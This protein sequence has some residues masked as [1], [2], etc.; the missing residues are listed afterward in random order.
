[1]PTRFYPVLIIALST[2]WLG[3]CAS[4]APSG[5]VADNA[6]H[7]A[8]AAPSPEA[9]M[10]FPKLTKGISAAEVRQKLG[11]PAEVQ[12]TPSPEGKAETWIYRYV[13][14]LGMTQVAAGTHD[15]PVLSVVPTAYGTTTIQEP[16]YKTVPKHAEIT[17]SL[18]MFNDH[19]EAQKAAVEEKI[20]HS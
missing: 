3:G 9:E 16:V 6:T 1:M 14:D 2:V 17:L 20:D 12:S 8:K 7:S 5:T 19:L 15:V 4:S 13:K 18:L 11:A 10:P